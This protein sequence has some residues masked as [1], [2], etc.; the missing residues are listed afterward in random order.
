MLFGHHIYHMFYVHIVSMY[1]YI[2]EYINIDNHRL[3]GLKM[4]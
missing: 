2:N 1:V 3:S 4:I